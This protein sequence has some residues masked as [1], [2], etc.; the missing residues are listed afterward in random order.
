MRRPLVSAVIFDFDGV[1]A[2]TESL[3]YA[4]FQ[5]I[6]SEIGVSLSL[7]Q[8]IDRFLGLA[9]REALAAMSTAAGTSVDAAVLDDLIARK[10]RAFAHLLPQARLYDG[11]EPVLRQLHAQLRLAI[12]SGAFHDEIETILE[13]ERVRGLFTAIVG[14]DDVRAGKPAPD[15]FLRALEDLN[16]GA[17]TRLS[18]AECVVIEDAPRG[19]EAARAAGMRCIA[20]T[21]NHDRSALGAADKI[22]EHLSQLRPEDLLA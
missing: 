17:T 2:D 16:R 15:P 3:H 4:A 22:I 12:A 18:A 8:Y 21:T 5:T 14:A 6:A 7:E 10:R 11:V 13:R 20:V 19:I 9:D 1:L